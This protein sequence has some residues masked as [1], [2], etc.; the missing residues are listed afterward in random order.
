MYMYTSNT[1]FD[2]RD[3]AAYQ[4]YGLSIVTGYC[5]RLPGGGG[6]GGR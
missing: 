5:I 4:Y 2:A 1:G 6:G 3:L